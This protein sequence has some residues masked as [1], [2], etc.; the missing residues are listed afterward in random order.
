MATY[1]GCSTQD[2]EPILPSS[3]SLYYGTYEYFDDS[4]CSSLLHYQAVVDQQCVVIGGASMFV[5]YPTQNIYSTPNCTGPVTTISSFETACTNYLHSP[6]VQRVTREYVELEDLAYYMDSKPQFSYRSS[7][8]LQGAPVDSNSNDS[9]SAGAIAGITIGSIAAVTIISF[10]VYYFFA[11]KFATSAAASTST[12]TSAPAAS[13][14]TIEV[15][16]PVHGE[17]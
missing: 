12:S 4:Q 7:N 6:F 8:I 14:E 9:L 11:S 5:E 17:K 15:E 16:N 1:Y 10:V 2:M 3:Q 13:I